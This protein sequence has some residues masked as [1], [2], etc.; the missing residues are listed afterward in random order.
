VKLKLLNENLSRKIAD[1]E[2]LM[3]VFNVPVERSEFVNSDLNALVRALLGDMQDEVQSA[4]ISIDTLPSLCISPRLMRPVLKNIIRNTLLHQ[5]NISPVIRIHSEIPAAEDE[6][7]RNPSGPK[8]CNIFVEDHYN[9]FQAGV[10]SDV[11][12]EFC[13]T[14]LGLSFCQKILEHH[15]GHISKKSRIDEGLTYIISLPVESTN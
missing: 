14:E 15:K 10:G 4:T 6:C 12:S 1:L 13:D 5:R 8:Y 2:S 7:D 9:G 3:S 11:T